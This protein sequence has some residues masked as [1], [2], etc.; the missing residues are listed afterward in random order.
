MWAVTEAWQ[1]DLEGN[2]QA[3][4]KWTDNNRETQG[5][6]RAEDDGV[7]RPYIRDVHLAP[8]SGHHRIAGLEF[9]ASTPNLEAWYQA[10]QRPA[11]KD[12]ALRGQNSVT[13]AGLQ[14]KS[15]ILV[16]PRLKN[17][18]CLEKRQVLKPRLR[19]DLQATGPAGD[20][21]T[22]Q[23]YQQ[24]FTH[25]VEWLHLWVSYPPQRQMA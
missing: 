1:S 13:E 23:C 12:I 21:L 16:R 5:E 20:G 19:L 10:E 6:Q 14:D 25:I 17:V 8:G 11:W 18:P 2:D 7:G 4:L 22:V 9:R 15:L 3:L 24:D